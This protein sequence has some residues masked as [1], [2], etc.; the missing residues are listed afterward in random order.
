M[1]D[2]TAHSLDQM[3]K[4]FGKTASSIHKVIFVT[5]VL[6][7]LVL[8]GSWKLAQVNDVS[9]K[10]THAQTSRP[11]I[12]DH[13]SVALFDQIPPQ[14]LEAARNLH[15]VFSDRSVGQNTHEVLDCFAGATEWYNIPSVCRRDYTTVTG[16]TWNYKTFTKADYDSGAVPARILFDPDPVLYDRSNWTFVPKAG[17]WYSLTQDFVQNIV[18]TYVNNNDVLSYQ[19]SY[20]NIQD[21][22]NYQIN[23]PTC[24]FF[25]TSDR[26]SCPSY[27]KDWS[28]QSI[29][30]LEQQYPN[31]TFIYWTT[32]LARSMGTNTATEFNNSMRQF[33]IQNNKILF[34]FAD[35]ESHTDTGAPCYDNRDGVEYCATNGR[36]E[37][38]PDDGLNI[39]ALCQDYTTETE[40]GH[41]GS[42]S[43]GGIAVGKAMWVLMAEIA[44]WNPSGASSIP[45]PSTYPS[46]TVAPSV[47]PTPSP[48]TNN[49][50]SVSVGPDQSVAITQ[51]AQL[52]A[53]VTDDGLPTGQ[54]TVTWSKTSGPGTVSFVNP[55]VTSTTATF[56]AAGTYVLRATANDGE[57]EGFDELTVTVQSSGGTGGAGP[58]A[59]WSFDNDSILDTIGGCDCV[60]YGTVSAPG[61]S[62]DG[63]SFNGSTT[64]MSL[65]AFNYLNNAA[66]FTVNIWLK[67]TT[68]AGTTQISLYGRENFYT[69]YLGNGKFRTGVRMNGVNRR[70]DTSVL[71]WTPNTWHKHTVT[72]DGANLNLYWDG[73]L[74]GTSPVVGTVDDFGSKAY[75][76]AS[77]ARNTVFP[78]VLDEL[79]VYTRALTPAEIQAL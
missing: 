73:V 54:Y 11:I 48:V 59:Y 16:S 67:P 30:N 24:G 72:Y 63:R 60:N 51:F 33:A 34:D 74:T 40:G 13:T 66:A 53:T 55:Y 29:V 46:P 57:L 41:L 38:Q 22:N 50:P 61:V 52:N 78:G 32:S 56:S 71:S 35:I 39:P 42:I 5:F 75:L 37:N 19:F 27:L 44:G 28:V 21:T 4:K 3:G 15:M 31:K 12:V 64:Y 18:P 70:V 69:I 25:G 65:G 43:T 79:K 20:L 6:S 68:T 1:N 47:N 14:Y 8:V 49:P 36:C 76:G 2:L 23:D 7:V 9:T 45:L 77:V 62:G 10:N 17:S 26:S 58:V